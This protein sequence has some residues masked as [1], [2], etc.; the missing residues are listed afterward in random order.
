MKKLLIC[1]ANITQLDSFCDS[2]FLKNISIIYR[3][4]FLIGKVD[5][6]DVSRIKKINKFGNIIE[7]SGINKN[8]SK[9]SIRQKLNL[10]WL[11]D[12]FFS[13]LSKIYSE[14]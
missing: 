11:F 7:S 2:D 14:Y 1:S 10:F 5:K 3:L 12:Q 8:L 9:N 13:T 6:E 4:T